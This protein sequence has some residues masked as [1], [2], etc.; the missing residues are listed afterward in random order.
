M[1]LHLGADHWTN[2]DVQQMTFQYIQNAL[3]GKLFGLNSMESDLE[4]LAVAQI[5]Q[6]NR[7]VY[8]RLDLKVARLIHFIM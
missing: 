7:T 5:K 2:H 6:L 1:L 3:K 8:P 4:E